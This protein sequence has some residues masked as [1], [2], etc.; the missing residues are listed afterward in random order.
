MFVSDFVVRY[1][2]YTALL[3]DGLIVMLSMKKMIT[4]MIIMIVVMMIIMM[5][6]LMQ[7]IDGD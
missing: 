2:M 6:K 4:W 3:I 5:I 1:F 7:M